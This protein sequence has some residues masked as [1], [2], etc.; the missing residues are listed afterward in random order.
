MADAQIRYHEQPRTNTKIRIFSFGPES[1]FHTVQKYLPSI[2]KQKLLH[3]K[4][5]NYWSVEPWTTSGL[6]VTN[7]LRFLINLEFGRADISQFSSCDVN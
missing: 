3:L 2:N 7:V 6:L 4:P 5:S 1:Y